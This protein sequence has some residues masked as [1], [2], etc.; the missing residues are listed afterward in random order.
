MKVTLKIILICTVLL[1]VWSLQLS[2]Q[3]VSAETDTDAHSPEDLIKETIYLD[4]TTSN[5][6]E[7]QGW[8]QNLDLQ[9]KG[10]RQ[11]LEN[12]LLEY[13]RTLFSEVP[14]TNFKEP[15]SDSSKTGV[16]NIQI[17]SAQELKYI[18]QGEEQALIEL[19]GGVSLYMRDTEGNTSHSVTAKTLLFNQQKNSITAQ[20]GVLYRMEQDGS[21]QE[22]QGEQISFNIENYSGVFIRG[23]SS[24][25]SE[26]EE[27]Q[28]NFYFKGGSIYRIKRDIVHLENGIISSSRIES[29]YYHISA[30]NVWI[31]GLNEWALQNA[32]LYVGHIPLLYV[33]F[34]YRPGASFVLHPSVGV[35]TV[36]GYY[37]Q[38]TTY[39]LG[40]QPEELRKQSSLSFMQAL[41]EE[42]QE[43]NQELRGFFLHSTRKKTEPSWA[44]STGSFGKLQVDYYSRLGMLSA[45]NFKVRKLGW[46]DKLDLLAGIG[47]TNYIYPLSNYPGTYT[48]FTFDPTTKQ[49]S[50]A[51]QNSYFFGTELPFRF[52]FD[53]ELEYKR[54]SFRTSL[55]APLYT[56]LQLHDQL[57]NRDE[58]LG[59]AKLL[60]G[61]EIQETSDTS[62]FTNPKFYQH[63]TFRWSLAE[64]SKYIDSF[65]IS[66]IDSRL[67]LSQN[68]LDADEGSLNQI[69]Y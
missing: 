51:P 16:N 31:L 60:T 58:T 38:T 69:G 46:I 2:A 48:S 41:D 36:E 37:F 5:Y 59:W 22:F 53:L 33:P 9:Q 45:L 35:K 56:D 8:L 7:L 66:K 27:N 28:I 34:Y 67:T 63:T 19:D 21:D 42:K 24:R 11:D 39:F 32:T 54:D 25:V 64:K 10:S 12:R 17:E 6:Y 40:R 57:R 26:I 18:P 13:Y 68:K 1:T 29:P 15:S 23:M 20:G 52:S 50:S 47:L 65:N 49:Y 62:E 43:Y 44:E 55:K 4:I 14:R 30:G 3:T 61:E